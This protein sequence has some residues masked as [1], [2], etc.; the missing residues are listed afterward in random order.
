[1]QKKLMAAAIA[2]LFVSGSAFAGGHGHWGYEGASGPEHW[3]ELEPQ[4][5]T[6]AQGKTQTP[7]DIKNEF[8]AAQSQP[9]TFNYAS[10]A[11]EIVNNGHTVQ[12]NIPA[13]NSI[14]IEG[15]QFELKQFHFHTPSENAVHGKRAAMEMHLVHADK[16]GNL[17]VVAVMIEEGKANDVL[18][19]LWK[20]MPKHAGDKHALQAQVNPSA[21]LPKE[22]HYFRFDG[23]LTT[24]PCSE[25]VRWMVMQQPISAS[26]A[27]VE[28]FAH[29][30][31]EH[32]ARPLQ[33][34]NARVIVAE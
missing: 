32:N 17:A 5:T 2:S 1:M 9:I 10:N 29:A 7:I 21:L 33:P 12:A 31:H 28:A 30:V 14:T 11:S 24:P 6:C 13:G 8:Q 4:F 18:A 19:K 3:G 15:V 22:Q 20:E 23:S 34:M 27:Q 25:G 26:K 16:D